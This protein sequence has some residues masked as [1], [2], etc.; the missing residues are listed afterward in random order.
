[1]GAVETKVEFVL[2][3][4]ALTS[5]RSSGHDVT[6]AVGEVIDNAIEANANKIFVKLESESKKVGGNKKAVPVIERVIIGD[7]GDGMTAEVLHHALQLGFSS[8]YNSRKG[9]GRFGVGAKLAGISQA[10]KIE[11][12]SRA[13][14]SNGW[15]YTYVDLDEIKAGAL[16]FIPEPTEQSLPAE[17]K[18]LVGKK[19]GTLVIWSKADRLQQRDSGGARTADSVKSDVI[20]YV[21]RT[22]R[23]FIDAGIKITVDD[24][25]VKPHDPL[26][27]MTSTRFHEGSDPDPVA[28]I[29]IDKEN[30]SFDWPVPSD[31]TRT[32][33]VEVTMTLLPEKFRPEQGSGGKDLAKSRR[34]DENE[35]VS[36]LRA[37]REIFFGILRGVQ[38]AVMD[39]DRWVGIEIRF[40]P[41]LDE[42]FHVRN[43][44]KGAEPVNGLRD[45]LHS[46]IFKTVQTARKQVQSHWASKEAERHRERGVHAEAE[47]IAAKTA[48]ISPKP[49]AGQD[50]P[51]ETRDEKIAEVAKTLTQD[52]PERAAEVAK[53]IKGRRFTIV[54]DSWSG[55]DFIE[56]VHLGDAGIIK[57]N[58]LHPFYRKVYAPLIADAEAE[59]ASGD[60]ENSKARVAQIGLD[61]LLIAYAAAEGMCDNPNDRYS[62]LRSYWSVHLKNLIQ[63]WTKF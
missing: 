44:K 27:L 21:A 28:S 5:L 34:I 46:M 20:S 38:P 54:T 55:S 7:D 14:D 17:F 35:G 9:M 39:I 15:L 33:R 6:S 10:K 50:T 59:I 36:I 19:K 63:T 37:N 42:C 61:L 30:G 53:E 58:T 41:E 49:Q 16:R 62:D 43:V 40:E 11:M 52:H 47:D 18:D 51:E 60:K 31:P 56:V 26:F 3:D 23:K 4:Q 25:Q 32:S 2:A 1:M 24:A 13:K 45:K 48:D 29:L 8:R 12:Y 22:F 57:L